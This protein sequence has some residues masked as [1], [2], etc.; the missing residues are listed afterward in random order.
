MNL[1]AF[2]TSQPIEQ[3]DIA[4][5]AF[6][7][8]CTHETLDRVTHTDKYTHCSTCGQAFEIITPY[9]IKAVEV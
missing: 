6:P 1:Q 8:P 5:K 3:Q 2:W 4:K 7:P 9:V